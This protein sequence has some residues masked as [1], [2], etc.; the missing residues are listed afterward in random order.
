VF[1][2]GLNIAEFHKPDRQQLL[3]YIHLVYRLFLSVY[4]HNKP[5]IAAI[6]GAV[7]LN[8]S[9]MWHAGCS[10]GAAPAGGCWL[11]LLADY[12]IM[13]DDPKAVI[14][15]N[16]TQLG[17]VEAL[18]YATGGL[19]TAISEPQASL[20]RIFSASRLLDALAGVKLNASCRYCISNVLRIAALLQGTIEAARLP[21]F[22]KGGVN[23]R[24]G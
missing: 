24:T 2:G 4:I 20:R 21:D 19:L 15:L 8:L 12:R 7:A 14:G 22:R 17:G 5:V 11:S 16:E 9:V 6:T 13:A 10:V 3:E 18:C 1:S 23:F